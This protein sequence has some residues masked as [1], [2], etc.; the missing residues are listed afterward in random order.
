M[1]FRSEVAGWT[2]KKK[3]VYFGH[4]DD[5]RTVWAAAHIGVLPSRVGEGMP[6]S[7][8]EAA[9]CGRP[10][11]AT[12]TP[13]CRDIVRN[14]VNGILVPAEDV[15]ALADAIDRLANDSDL[16]RRFGQAS[17]ELVE[18]EFSSARVGRDLVGLYRRLLPKLG[19][20]PEGR[21]SH[22]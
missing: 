16:R 14:G 20:S 21:P 22:I 9:A 8:I 10:L 19:A 7:M 15:Q 4:V 18:R 2:Q 17:R 1:L 5:I 11:I 12:D 3:V 13:G 6:L